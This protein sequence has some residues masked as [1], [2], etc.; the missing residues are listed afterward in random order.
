M[1][2]YCLLVHPSRN[3]RWTYELLKIS[4]LIVCLI[5]FIPLS[6]GSSADLSLLTTLNAEALMSHQAPAT[7][8]GVFELL[9]Q[10]RSQKALDLADDLLET[11]PHEPLLYL[12]KARVL[13]EILSEQDDNKKLIR[14]GAVPIHEILDE[15]I[16][17]CKNGPKD[18][19]EE[20]KFKFYLGWAWMFKAQLHALGGSYWSAGRAAAKGNKHLKKYLAENPDDPDARGI[21]GTFLYFADTLPTVVKIIKSFFLIPAGEGTRVHR[22]CLQPQRAPH[23]RAPDHPGRHPFD[24]RGAVRKRRLGVHQFTRTVS[25]LH[26]SSGAASCGC[27]VL[28][29]QSQAAAATRELDHYALCAKAC[30]ERRLEH[31][32]PPSI[33]QIIYKYVFRHPF[34]IHR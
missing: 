17:L 6:Q 14:K 34:P 21:L 9:Y 23:Y 1:H 27:H 19:Q 25:H 15:A 10:G 32:I 4:S 8:E 26:S 31:D 18:P 5:T 30:R 29:Q 20:A 2:I 24:I 13:R 22:V 7:P 33:S 12:I 3:P 11:E 16:E 28:S